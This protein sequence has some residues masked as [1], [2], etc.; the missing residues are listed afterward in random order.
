MKVE[1]I[2][3]LNFRVLLEFITENEKTAG[4]IYIP[5]ATTMKTQ[6]GRIINVAKEVTDI[7]PGD[8][9]MFDKYSGIT[10]DLVD[11]IDSAITHE[12]LITRREDIVAVVKEN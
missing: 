4:G 12:Y 2:R 6:F 8:K 11:E 10:F 9:V 1:D 5:N 3:V 7:E